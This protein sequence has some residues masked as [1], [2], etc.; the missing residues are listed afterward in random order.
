MTT[1]FVRD[2]FHGRAV[3]WL[4]EKMDVET[5]VLPTNVLATPE[6]PAHAYLDG[7]IVEGGRSDTAGFAALLLL[8]VAAILGMATARPGFLPPASTIL[9]GIA[10]AMLATAV[11]LITIDKM[12]VNARRR[13]LAVVVRASAASRVDPAALERWT[14]RSEATLW[15]VSESGFAPEALELAR[16][17]RVRCFAPFAGSIVEV[18]LAA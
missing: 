10:L 9:Q 13:A 18:G 7:H 12:R 14:A 17:R 11:A 16:A 6:E 1:N 8:M 2:P 4:R 5:D 15:V 3:T